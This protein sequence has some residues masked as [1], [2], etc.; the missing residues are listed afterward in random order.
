MSAAVVVA[1]LAVALSG[2]GSESGAGGSVLEGK[3]YLS[4]AVTE[5]GK[6][7]QLAPNTRIQLQ[8]MADGRL[9]ANAG[10]N[11]MGA[12]KISTSGGKL[13]VKDLAITDMGCDAPRHAQDDWLSK[14]LTS[15][16]TW[17]LTDDKL[18]L[19]S[20]TT[21]ISLVDR[22]TAEPDL[23]LDGTKW[24]L[25]TVITGETAS[26]SAEVAKVHLTISGERV[27]GSTG[28]NDFQG[29]VSRTGDKLTFGE[30]SATL[31]ACK[32][33][34]A[35]LEKTILGALKGE[36]VYGITSNNLQLSPTNAPGTSLAFTGTR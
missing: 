16:P 19:S 34:V 30:L 36:V 11:S 25:E 22:Q 7:K 24:T 1:G 23:V 2:C 17:K 5:S 14:L 3:S 4:T 20:G 9:N 35:T 15:E 32:G 26:H 31:R 28:C 29:I 6:P 12:A 8:F 33:D 13:G 27:T 21:V 18:E 10:C